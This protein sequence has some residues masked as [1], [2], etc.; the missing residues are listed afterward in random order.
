MGSS[1]PDNP[2]ALPAVVSALRAARVALGWTQHELA[3]ASGVS[4]VTIARLESGVISSKMSTLL[5]L[6]AA[7]ERAGAHTTLNDPVG[8]YTLRVQG[9]ETRTGVSHRSQG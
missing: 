5:A 2:V 4:K 8:G 6:Q 3:N 7:L 1:R 9:G